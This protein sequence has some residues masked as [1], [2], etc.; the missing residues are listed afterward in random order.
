MDT[1]TTLLQCLFIMSE[2][3]LFFFW[4]IRYLRLR[5]KYYAPQVWLDLD[6]NSWPP[7]HESTFHVT[8]TPAL[9]TWPSVTVCCHNNVMHF[10]PRSWRLLR[11]C[12]CNGGTVESRAC[13]CGIMYIQIAYLTNNIVKFTAVDKN[14]VNDVHF[15][16]THISEVTHLDFPFNKK[17]EWR[18]CSVFSAVQSNIHVSQSFD[19]E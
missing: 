8:K 9:T 5:Q 16:Q 3:V 10:L 7:D 1:V 11:H 6:L 17:L 19:T 2:T 13:Y 15:Q 4:S 18:I 14:M 12:K